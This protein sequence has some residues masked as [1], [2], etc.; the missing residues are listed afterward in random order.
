MENGIIWTSKVTEEQSKKE[1]EDR[2]KRCLWA[3]LGPYE[4]NKEAA[5]DYLRDE[6][7]EELMVLSEDFSQNLVEGGKVEMF[8][9]EQLVFE[10]EIEDEAYESLYSCTKYESIYGRETT[11]KRKNG[12][13]VIEVD[14]EDWLTKE[15]GTNC[16]TIKINGEAVN[17]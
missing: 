8:E 7:F 12:E 14:W 5:I 4:E 13:L 10:I 16:Y 2:R 15:K 6:K 9:K 1:W 11:L 17:F 3:N